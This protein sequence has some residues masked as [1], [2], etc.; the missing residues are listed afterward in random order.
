MSTPKAPA[1]PPGR[2]RPCPS[3]GRAGLARGPQSQCRTRAANGFHSPP[4]P[5]SPDLYMAFPHPTSRPSRETSGKLEKL[6]EGAPAPP[7]K[8]KALP[9]TAPAPTP[10][11]AG[12]HPAPGSYC[13]PHRTG[14][15]HPGSPCLEAG[16]PGFARL[17]S[18]RASFDSAE[19]LHL[20]GSSERL[21]GGHMGL[22][23]PTPRR[24]A[25]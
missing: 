3:P 6:P 7:K 9:Q 11:S 22:Q 24:G 5:R 15:R 13:P 8:A 4:R 10:P 17:Q 18:E 23:G 16:C 21:A 25:P 1:A 2:P 20:S 14:S 12:S 19:T